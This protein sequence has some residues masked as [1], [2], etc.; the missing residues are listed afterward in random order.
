MHPRETDVLPS[1]T[2]HS[3]KTQHLCGHSSCTCN[4]DK[5][6]TALWGLSISRER[7]KHCVLIFWKSV[8]QYSTNPSTARSSRSPRSMTAPRKVAG[9]HR[10]LACTGPAVADMWCCQLADERSICLADSLFFNTM[11]TNKCRHIIFQNIISLFL[12]E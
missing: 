9:I 1:P 3:K 2:V 8:P 6:D 12:K 10:A 4:G 7:G 5:H 11:K